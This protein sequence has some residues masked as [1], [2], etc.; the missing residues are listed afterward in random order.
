MAS[1]GIEQMS[2]VLKK[3]S[4]KRYGTITK[5]KESLI[6]RVDIPRDTLV[7][8]VTAD[9]FSGKI[10]VPSFSY[11]VKQTDDG[12][13]IVNLNYRFA[14]PSMFY[15]PKRGELE[16]FQSAIDTCVNSVFPSR[17]S[18]RTNVSMATEML[19]EF[20]NGCNDRVIQAIEQE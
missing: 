4:N 17:A 5:L 8:S 16:A 2:M 18:R 7:L 1:R 11:D 12:K 13:Y 15:D 19:I 9:T 20:L 3:S 6:N 14:I 10:I